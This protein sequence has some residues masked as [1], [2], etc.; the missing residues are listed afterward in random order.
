MRSAR[1]AESEQRTVCAHPISHRLHEHGAFIADRQA[2]FRVNKPVVSAITLPG[3]L[4]SAQPDLRPCRVEN[5]IVSRCTRP[6]QY[7]NKQARALWENGNLKAASRDET[8]KI[9]PC[10]VCNQCG[11]STKSRAS[12]VSLQSSRTLRFG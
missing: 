4:A 6:L 9:E 11:F 1:P 12:M 10:S 3:R 8:S 5:Q 2:W 7:A